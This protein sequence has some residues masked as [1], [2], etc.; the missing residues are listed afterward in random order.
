MSQVLVP[1]L[2]QAKVA[3]GGRRL[4]ALVAEVVDGKDAPG[5]LQASQRVPT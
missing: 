1:V 4:H 2:W 5:I 3:V